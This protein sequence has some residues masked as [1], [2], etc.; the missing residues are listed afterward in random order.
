MKFRHNLN[1]GHNHIRHDSIKHSVTGNQLVL[2]FGLNQEASFANYFG[3][4]NAR[5][6]SMLACAISDA[7]ESYI[8]IAGPEGVGKSHLAFSALKQF[9]ETGRQVGYVALDELEDIPDSALE[10]FFDDLYAFDLLV[11]EDVH[12]WLD[13]RVRE[14]ALFNLFND[15][16]AM[17]RCLILTSNCT[18]SQMVLSLPDL[19]SRLLSGLSL[20]LEP[21]RDDEKET[22]LRRVADSRGLDM[23]IDVSSYIIKRSARN[24]GQL[25]NVLDALDRALWVE[26]RMLTVPFVKK[27]MAW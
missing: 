27:V 9:E 25:L 11:L 1:T 23:S 7:V 22:A 10:S 13:S 2:P 8:F 3:E 20:R 24:M 17:E 19:A 6:A 5:P 16:K 18:V 12:D 4:T 21:L 26:K 14:T 15:F